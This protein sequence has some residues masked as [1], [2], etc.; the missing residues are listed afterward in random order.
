MIGG[1]GGGGCSILYRVLVEY[2]LKFIV[3]SKQF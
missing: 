1:G 2:L 3:L